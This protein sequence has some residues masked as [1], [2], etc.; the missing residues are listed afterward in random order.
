M[1]LLY[2]KSGEPVQIGP[3]IGRPGGG[4]IAKS[5]L[6]TL[7]IDFFPTVAHEENISDPGEAVA[8]EEGLVTPIPLLEKTSAVT[9]PD[10]PDKVY[11]HDDDLLIETDVTADALDSPEIADQFSSGADNAIGGTSTTWLAQ[12][13]TTD[14]IGYTILGVRVMLYRTSTIGTIT[15]AIKATDVNGHPTGADLISATIDGSITDAIQ[16]ENSGDFYDFMFAAGY[17]LAP[18]TKYAVVVTV[19]SGTIYWRYNSTGSYA[20]GNREHSTNS[21]GSWTAYSAHDYMFQ[22]IKTEMGDV[23]PFPTVAAVGDGL[24]VGNS[25]QFDTVRLWVNRQGL[26]TFTITAKYY[27]GSTWL[28]LTLLGSGDQIFSYKRSGHRWLSFIRPTDWA[29]FTVDGNSL[30]WVKFEVTA[31]SS[32]TQMPKI[33]NVSIGVYA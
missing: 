14:G 32:M 28:A 7:E 20:G 29:M 8:M 27:N 2:G 31:Y 26:G 25:T 16:T 12:T 9:L 23:E 22:T 5:V 13:F 11:K 3:L 33:G 19:S 21:G 24:Y 30:Y 10:D 4:D 6:K 1:S 15:V 17:A 18:T